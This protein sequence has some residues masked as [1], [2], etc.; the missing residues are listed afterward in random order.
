[1]TLTNQ[2]AGWSLQATAARTAIGTTGS[3]V[4]G[5]QNGSAAF[6]DAN[7]AYSFK[8]TAVAASNKATLTVTSG[9]VAQTTGTPSIT[10]RGTEIDNLAAVDFEGAALPTMAT[11]YAI[12]IEPGS[13]NTGPLNIVSSEPENPTQSLDDNTTNFPLFTQLIAAGTI[14]FELGTGDTVTVTVIGKTA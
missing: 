3:A 12:L 9:A 13:S 5:V 14:S 8:V 6:T 2:R 11:G 1:M 7:I 10:R 4:I